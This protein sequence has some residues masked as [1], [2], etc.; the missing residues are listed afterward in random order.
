MI[1]SFAALPRYDEAIERGSIDP[2]AYWRSMY[3]HPLRNQKYPT[4][5]VFAYD[6]E[7][8][9]ELPFRE[10]YEVK[11]ERPD[12]ITLK[13]VPRVSAKVDI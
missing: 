13:R 2:S 6:E 9:H 11:P 3:T 5:A 12:N 7:G 4:Y 10:D 8:L 1:T